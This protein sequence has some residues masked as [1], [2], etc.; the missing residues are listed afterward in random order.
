MAFKVE[1]QNLGK[2]KGPPI[3]VGGLTVLAGPNATGKSF[4]SKALYSVFNAMNANHA[5]MYVQSLIEPIDVHLRR[6][7]RHNTGTPYE[8][9]RSRLKELELICESLREHEDEFLAVS[10]AH[11]DLNNI[12][13]AA[14]NLYN[15]IRPSLKELTKRPRSRTFLLFDENKLKEVDQRVQDLKAFISQ[16]PED[17]VSEG[18]SLALVGNLVGNFQISESDLS[19][20]KRDMESDAWIKI[21]D[22]GKI[23]FQ[24]DG[25]PSTKIEPEGILRLQQHSRVIYLESPVHWKLRGAL[26]AVRTSSWHRHRHMNLDVPRYFYD[27]DIALGRQHSGKVAFPELL[28]KLKGAGIVGGEIVIDEGVMRF[29]DSTE[30]SGRSFPLPLTATGAVNLGILALLIERRVIDENTFLFIDEPEANLHPKWQV[31][32]ISALLEL[33]QGGVHVVIAT[34]SSDIVKRLL[35]LLKKYPQAEEL[36]AMNHFS[37]EGVKN[38]GAQNLHETANDI[39]EELATPYSDSHLMSEGLE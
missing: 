12:T 23:S 24:D 27:L 32:M 22:I 18:V 33:A 35:G 13:N 11:D 7:I 4:F 6:L 9:L 3:T 21:E 8:E 25:K 19:E 36:I 31:E 14:I 34:H 29:K 16:S 2:L 39:I 10:E 38:G 15:E 26:N 20:L 28:D 17:I 30:P 37:A 5:L 1:I